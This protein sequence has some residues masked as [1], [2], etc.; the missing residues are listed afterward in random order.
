MREPLIFLGSG[1]GAAVANHLWQ[2][3]VFAAIA[4][5]LILFLRRNSASMRCALWIAASVKFLVPFSLLIGLGGLFPQR[6]PVSIEPQMAVYSAINV[7]SRPFGILPPVT[8][9]VQHTRWIESFVTLL[10]ELLLSV[11]I[12]GAVAVLLVWYRRWRRLSAIMRKATTAEDG[13][14]VEILRQLEAASEDRRTDCAYAVA[15]HDGAGHIR[16]K[17]CEAACHAAIDAAVDASR[18]AQIGSASQHERG[19]SVFAGHRQERA[20]VQRDEP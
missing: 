14:E 13:R 4:G 11:W 19:S 9:P 2:S 12:L 16:A 20:E 18:S 8:S 7:A 5:L 15:G 1:I 17:S 6:R 3:T 10:P